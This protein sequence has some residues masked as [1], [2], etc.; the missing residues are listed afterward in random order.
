MDLTDPD[1]GEETELW[2]GWHPEPKKEAF[3]HSFGGLY[4]PDKAEL[5]QYRPE[6]F[7]V[8]IFQWIPK[9]NGKGLKKSAV[10]FRVKGSSKHPERVYEKAYEMCEF[11]DNGGKLTAKSCTV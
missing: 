7:S 3:R 6:T 5:I 8:G 4:T 2:P 11:L 9:A 1:T 10:K